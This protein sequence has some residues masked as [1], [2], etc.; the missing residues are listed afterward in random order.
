MKDFTP[1]MPQPGSP[2]WKRLEGRPGPSNFAKGVVAEPAAKGAPAPVPAAGGR[3]S[4]PARPAE[5]ARV[6][7]P[8]PP[9]PEPEPEPQAN[10]DEERQALLGRIEDLED[11]E[12]RRIIEHAEAMN[13][14]ALKERELEMAAA[15]L[16]VAARMIEGARHSVVAELRQGVGPVILEAARRIAGEQLHVD[17]KLLDAIVDEAARALGRESLVVRVHPG[18]AALLR[19]RLEGTGIRVVDDA[20]V[21]AGAVCEGPTGRIDAS[22]ESAVAAIASVLDQW[23]AAP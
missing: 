4:T 9:P 22:V 19:A 12:S 16:A 13:R 17:P 20:R 15:K 2:A 7:P 3:S 18:D 10:F 21:N 5:P 8:P 23:R 6:E 1:M 11:N 14:M